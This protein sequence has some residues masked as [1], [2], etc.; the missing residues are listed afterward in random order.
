MWP[1]PTP[2]R[3]RPAYTGWTQL[4]S[5]PYAAAVPG[6]AKRGKPPTRPLPGS[7]R[8]RR[9]SKRGSRARRC[10]S[11]SSSRTTSLSAC[12]CP[13]CHVCGNC[14]ISSRAWGRSLSRS[15][16]GEGRPWLCFCKYLFSWKH[17]FPAIFRSPPG[18]FL[19]STAR[20][21]FKA[22]RPGES[23]GGGSSL[24]SPS[25]GA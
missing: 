3:R 7:S 11:R 13:T 2:R 6:P 19:Q 18:I 14:D 16:A 9:A 5:G 15:N 23:L 24:S 10:R 25:G 4:A 22:T 8:L 1:P 20:G 17:V 12:Y 21:I